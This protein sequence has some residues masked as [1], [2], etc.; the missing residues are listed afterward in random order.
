MNTYLVDFR[1][2]IPRRFSG[3][4]RCVISE[5]NFLKFGERTVKEIPG[6][7]FGKMTSFLSIPNKIFWEIFEVN[8]SKILK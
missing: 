6:E 1:L 7:F 3:E 4:T 2:W 8:P 5:Q